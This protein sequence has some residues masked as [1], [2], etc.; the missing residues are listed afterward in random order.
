M[1]NL[2]RFVIYRL[3][4]MILIIGMHAL[5]QCVHAH[6][7]WWP[8][9]YFL[10]HTVNLNDQFFTFWKKWWHASSIMNQSQW[11]WAEGCIG[12][13]PTCPRNS[14][15]FDL[16][17]RSHGQFKCSIFGFLWKMVARFVIYESIPMVLGREMY[18]HSAYMPTKNYDL[19]P[20]FMVT[21]SI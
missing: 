10:G 18:W 3:I 19:W 2:T 13:V 9:T 6:K 16:L 4:S 11:Y 5:W 15:A 14:M 8:L 17:S 1:K 20:T 7:K 12:T 21:W